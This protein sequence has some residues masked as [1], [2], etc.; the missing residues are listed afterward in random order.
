MRKNYQTSTHRARYAGRVTPKKAKLDHDQATH[1]AAL[2][3]PDT[4]TVAIADLAGELEEGLLAFAVGT[5]LKVLD[6]VMDNEARLLA[7][8]R[9]KHDPDRTAVRH[10]TDS[11][12]VTL[13]GRQVPIM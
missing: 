7:G 11:G 8:E 9:G 6:V 13:G 12:L 5:G 3:L 4:V 1:E 2:A 10:G